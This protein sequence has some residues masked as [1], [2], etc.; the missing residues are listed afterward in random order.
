MELDNKTPCPAISW[1]NLDADGNTNITTVVRGKF[2]FYP[3]KDRTEWELRFAEEQGGLFGAD[4]FYNDDT[5]QSLQY[6]SDFVPVKLKTDVIINANSYSPHNKP[7]E[8]WLCGI[9]I[10]NRLGNIVL[11][12]CLQVTGERYWRRDFLGWTLDKPKLATK[13]PIRYEKAFGGQVVE[14]EEGKE[15]KYYA[16]CYSNPIGTGLLHKKHLDKVVPAP[17]IEDPDD[18]LDKL[19]PY[20]QIKPKGFGFYHRSWDFRLPLAGTYD[21][22]W[23]ENQ[24]PL[25]PHDFDLAFNQAAHP[26][27][28]VDDDYLKGNE[29][30]VLYNLLFGAEKQQFKLP[31]IKVVQRCLDSDSPIIVPLDLD[32]VVIDIESENSDDWVVY[33]SWRSIL[34]K[35]DKTSSSDVMMLLPDHLRA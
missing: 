23:K 18:T 11:E 10:K 6:E 14:K 16:V 25:P 15:D 12:N 17:Q 26:D 30:V 20:K 19:K 22:E 8:K 3:T 24:W 31:N 7:L 27:M 5:N 32:T 1:K 29:T 34:K 21:D 33:I 13:V 9:E 28:I 2:K 35:M 4:K